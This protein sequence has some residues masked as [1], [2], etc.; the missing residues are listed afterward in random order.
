LGSICVYDFYQLGQAPSLRE[1]CGGL[2]TSLG[3]M[4]HLGM[5]KAP[6]R[7]TLAYANEHRP[8]QLYEKL[9]FH[10]LKL[11]RDQFDGN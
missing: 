2:A 11:C 6:S 10:A 5:K 8:W 1:I 9:F 4:I 3:K 7:S